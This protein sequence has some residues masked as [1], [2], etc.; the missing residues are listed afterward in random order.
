MIVT[1]P[2]HGQARVKTIWIAQYQGHACVQIKIQSAGHE[3]VYSQRNIDVGE[4]LNP[5][6]AHARPIE[7]RNPT[8][9]VVTITLGLINHRPNWQVSLAPMLLTNVAPG[10]VRPVTLTVQPPTWEGLADERPIADVEAYINGALIGGIRK[11]AKPPVPLH[12]PQDPPYAESEISVHPLPLVA[13]KPATITAEVMNTSEVTQS[14]RVEFWVAS[15]GFG[16]PFTNTN[17]VPTYRVITLG[18]GISQ[19]RR[20]GVD[21]AA[22]G[23]LVHPDQARR[24][25]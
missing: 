14:I 12:K 22:A 6:V 25:E 23:Q 7:V 2:P 19:D 5:Q 3:P 15:Y 17:I 16:I 21:A 9:E 20:G 10:E 11:I 18:P 1:I 13:S 24:S 8:N 4:P